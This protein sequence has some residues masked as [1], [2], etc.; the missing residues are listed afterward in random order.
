MNCEGG[1]APVICILLDEPHTLSTERKKQVIGEIYAEGFL[2]CTFK[3]LRRKQYIFKD[4]H[5]CGKTMQQSKG[6][7]NIKIW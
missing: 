7:V 2:M 3:M 6:K 4:S 1:R 5:K